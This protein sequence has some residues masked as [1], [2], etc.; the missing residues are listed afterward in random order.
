MSRESEYQSSKP[1]HLA[2]NLLHTM[3]TACLQDYGLH[4]LDDS[5]M[6]RGML[7]SEIY[8]RQYSVS[9]CVENR[10]SGA[11]VQGA[12]SMLEKVMASN[13]DEDPYG[14]EDP[15]NG[16]DYDYAEEPMED[17]L[18]V[19]EDNHSETWP[20]PLNA[21][22]DLQ[23]LRPPARL[24]AMQS[25]EREWVHKLYA[26][27]N[28]C[29]FLCSRLKNAQNQVTIYHSQVSH[30]TKCYFM[31]E[32]NFQR[33]QMKI[34]R[35]VEHPNWAFE[36]SFRIGS[37]AMSFCIDSLVQLRHVMHDGEMLVTQCCRQDWWRMALTLP[38]I[39]PDFP[40]LRSMSPFAFNIREFVWSL[41]VVEFAF[42]IW[43]NGPTMH[44]TSLLSS[45][46]SHWAVEERHIRYT[47]L[48]S[49]KADEEREASDKKI[50]CLTLRYIVNATWY[51]PIEEEPDRYVFEVLIVKLEGP[52]P[53]PNLAP[54][55]F[56]ID[57]YQLEL[58]DTIGQ[59]SLGVVLKC[60]W[61]GEPVAVKV[62]TGGIDPVVLE[63]E[64][65]H[66]A[67]IQHPNIV[68]LIGCA[69]NQERRAA[70]FVMEVV[71]RDLRTLIELRSMN[72]QDSSPPFSL[73]QSVDIMLQIAEALQYLKDCKLMH[74]DIRA[75]K[76]L[77]TLCE[78]GEASAP[79][80]EYF[81]VKLADVGLSKFKLEMLQA[82]SFQ[83]EACRWRAPE[84]FRDEEMISKYSWPADVYSFAMTCF[85]V[86]T[87]E[88][89]FQGVPLNEV[90]QKVCAGVR[91]ELPPHCPP[92][93]SKYLA[94]CWAG[95]PNERPEFSEICER[96]RHWKCML[97][98]RKSIP[99]VPPSTTS[100]GNIIGEPWES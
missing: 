95:N 79:C 92:Y 23:L 97:L 77:I 20:P 71:G 44:T 89:P 3:T 41:N 93:I 51:N 60:K 16:D 19:F 81:H 66:V 5:K 72:F 90:Y 31:T 47:H 22:R 43:R 70:M 7:K 11:D 29:L 98:L 13:T 67:G 63:A 84:V 12:G 54:D 36:Q 78:A 80:W 49:L 17:D 38:C 62:L 42:H 94:K 2:E 53:S 9:N 85:E 57:Q 58:H 27:M 10:A 30:L 21:E 64:A 52:E 86:L 73:L 48:Y 8:S 87:G 37:E 26:A 96:L 40:R 82:S 35:A 99:A 46:F 50:M 88:V 18:E 25:V 100:T 45:A 55:S 33:Y 75:R 32:E 68:K 83:T 6:L 69:Y 39:G 59:G 4:L 65:A 56:W 61:F 76:V 91:P 34:M 24:E 28:D 74:R 14:F 15:Y 1:S